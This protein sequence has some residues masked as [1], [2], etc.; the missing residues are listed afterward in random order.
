[1]IS[2]LVKQM[3]SLA[4][5]ERRLVS[6][7]SCRAPAPAPPSRISRCAPCSRSSLYDCAKRSNGVSSAKDEARWLTA[8]NA[9]AQQAGVSGAL[10]ICDCLDAAL[11]CEKDV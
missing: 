11:Y 8:T 2:G 9:A 7:A 10:S 3:I 5:P 6:P 4:A 1:M